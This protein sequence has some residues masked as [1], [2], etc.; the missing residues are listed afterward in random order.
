MSLC[1]CFKI[2]RT[3]IHFHPYPRPYRFPVSLLVLRPASLPGPGLRCSSSP[4][5]SLV[6][7]DSYFSTSMNPAPSPEEGGRSFPPGLSSSHRQ[8]CHHRKKVYSCG[9]QRRRL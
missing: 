5:K 9:L 7:I 4:L 1:L 2:M 6:I 8:P 3:I